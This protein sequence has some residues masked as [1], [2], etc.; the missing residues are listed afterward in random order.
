MP[1]DG[2]VLNIRDGV[3]NRTFFSCLAG[4]PLVLASGLLF[5]VLPLEFFFFFL[6]LFDLWKI[7]HRC[8]HYAFPQRSIGRPSL[9]IGALAGGV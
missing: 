3:E 8:C 6:F 1:S 4:W 5:G 2:T 7:L 9:R